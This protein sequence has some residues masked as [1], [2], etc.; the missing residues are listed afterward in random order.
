MARAYLKKLKM[1][2]S[3]AEHGFSLIEVMVSMALLA[4][5]ATIAMNKLHM[6]ASA[7][8]A[9]SSGQSFASLSSAFRG[10]VANKLKLYVDQYAAGTLQVKDLPAAMG[11]SSATLSGMSYSL[12][13]SSSPIGG[14]E[15]PAG[16]DASSAKS[17]CNTKSPTFTSTTLY[18]CVKWNLPNDQ[19]ASFGNLVNVEKPIFVEMLF[20]MQNSTTFNALNFSQYKSDPNASGRIYFG[21]SW[22]PKKAGKESSDDM[23][24]KTFSGIQYVAK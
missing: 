3:Q 16:S 4:V 11:A 22:A 23:V 8:S 15:F 6:A 18:L 14:G 10:Q 13:T 9:A 21:M 24:S 5:I 19:G 17:R 1:F 2:G 7:V 12:V 20:V